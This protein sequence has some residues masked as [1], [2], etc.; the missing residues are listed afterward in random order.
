MS[1][2]IIGILVSHIAYCYYRRRFRNRKPKRNRNQQPTEADSTYQE[3]DLSKMNK[4]DN[5]YQSLRKNKCNVDNDYDPT[6]MNP[7]QLQETQLNFKLELHTYSDII[8]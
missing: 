6:Y 7:E 2:I 3:L 5:I 8:K 1:G 4:E